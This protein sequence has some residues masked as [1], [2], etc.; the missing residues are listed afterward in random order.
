MELEHMRCGTHCVRQDKMLFK[1]LKRKKNANLN[2][3]RRN[4][5]GNK[6][7]VRFDFE[8]WSNLSWV[9]Y[10]VQWH[11]S[12]DAECWYSQTEYTNEWISRLKVDRLAQ[13][14]S[15]SLIALSVKCFDIYFSIMPDSIWAHFRFPSMRWKRK[16]EKVFAVFLSNVHT[17]AVFPHWKDQRIFER[18][19]NHALCTINATNRI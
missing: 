12:G 10:K 19:I 9:I 7:F 11:V 5:K 3:L 13:K 18:T 4:W 6:W 16:R 14:K 8:N 17:E 15:H 2:E 1:M